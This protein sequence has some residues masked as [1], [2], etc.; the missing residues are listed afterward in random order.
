MLT[1]LFQNESGIKISHLSLDNF[2]IAIAPETFFNINKC[3]KMDD[4]KLCVGKT[5]KE[6]IKPFLLVVH[7]FMSTCSEDL[8]IELV[9]LVFEANIGVLV[10]LLSSVGLREL[11]K[12]LKSFEI[13]CN[14]YS[15]VL[16][17]KKILF[18]ET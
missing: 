18:L 9:T 12:V 8:S 2:D 15:F 7:Q 13:C 3:E 4:Y 11:M 1:Y 16:G 14:S 10:T 17:I 6:R 5:I